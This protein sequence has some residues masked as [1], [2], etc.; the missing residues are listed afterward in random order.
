MIHRLHFN[1]DAIFLL[2]CFVDSRLRVLSLDS[3]VLRAEFLICSFLFFQYRKV[4]RSLWNSGWVLFWMQILSLLLPHYNTG[5]NLGIFSSSEAATQGAV[6]ILWFWHRSLNV[7]IKKH[8]WLSNL[9]LLY[10]SLLS[11]KPRD[12]HKDVANTTDGVLIL[13]IISHGA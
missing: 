7:K 13:S 10:F 8:L 4:P 1:K 9:C 2:S 5:S 11:P 6:Y 3:M 12:T